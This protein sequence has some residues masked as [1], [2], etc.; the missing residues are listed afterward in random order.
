METGFFNCL[1]PSAYC[2]LFRRRMTVTRSATLSRRPS[3]CVRCCSS[4][5]RPRRRRRTSR[6]SKDRAPLLVGRAHGQPRASARA[7]YRP[8]LRRA[9]GRQGHTVQGLQ[10]DGERRRHIPLRRPA[11]RPQGRARLVRTALLSS[12]A[13]CCA[14]PTASIARSTRR[15]TFGASNGRR[16]LPHHARPLRRRRPLEQRA[17]GRAARSQRPRKPA[18]V[19]RRRPTRHHR[20]PAVF[21]GVGRDGPLD[22]AVVR[23]LERRQPLRQALVPEHLLPRLSRGRLLRGRRSLR[24]VGD[25][26]GAGREG[27]RARHQNHSGSGRQPRRLAARV[28]EEPA[29]PGLVPRHARAV[30]SA[31]PSA[32]TCCS[33]RTRRRRRGGTRSTAGSPTTCPT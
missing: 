6:S 32:A 29:A 3:P 18:R 33:R 21:E 5:L 19:A 2:L 14:S 13:G 30:T 24:D 4:R 26:A 22:D 31:T 28:G 10:P 15:R 16:H 9:A 12:V 8:A 7:R 1:L 17:A 11:H 20:P 25:V 23:Q 27:A